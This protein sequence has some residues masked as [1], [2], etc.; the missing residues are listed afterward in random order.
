VNGTFTSALDVVDNYMFTVGMMAGTN[1]TT[2]EPMNA[3]RF[4]VS[5]SDIESFV[6]S[7]E[8]YRTGSCPDAPLYRPT[9]S[10]TFREGRKNDIIRTSSGM[11]MKSDSVYDTLCLGKG[12]ETQRLCLDNQEFNMVNQI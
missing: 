10:S 11:R 9:I 2:N 8:C 4:L 7:D 3:G 5:T 6:Y 1:G 12:N